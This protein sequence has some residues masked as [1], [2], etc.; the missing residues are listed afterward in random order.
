MDF[1]DSPDEAAYRARVREYLHVHE[2]DLDRGPSDAGGGP[3]DPRTRALR[4]TQAVLYAGGLVGVTW[5]LAYGGQGLSAM[6][7]AIVDQELTRAGI[8]RLINHIG[9][10]MCGPT[11]IAHG[12]EEQRQRY[13][14]RLLSGEDVWCQLFS[15]PSAGS[16]LAAMRTRA[17]R[18]HDTW[19]V[20]GQ[21]V[22]TTGAQIARYG[23]LLARTSPDL[24]KHQGLT[25]FVIDMH[26]SGVQ[27][28]PLRQMSGGT[29]FNEV[30]LDG[31]GIPDRE[32]LGQVGQ[33]W[34]VA[35]TTLLH[36]RSAIGAD[37]KELGAGSDAL[38]ALA[39]T[40]LPGLPTARQAVLRQALGRA[41][42]ESLA[43]RYTG[44]RSL[45]QLSR[46]RLPGPEASAGKLA[47]VRAAKRVADLGVRLL[48]GGQAA[49]F[50]QEDSPALRF[51]TAQAE[52]P[53]M[54]IAG[55]TDEI[56][57]N[58]IGER[59]LGLPREPRPDRAHRS[60]GEHTP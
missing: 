30:F 11:V 56:L 52:L 33:G 5:P 40:H 50:P 39:A 12:S 13:L 23:I 27:V 60:G 15:E 19:T 16:D 44:Y 25:M 58:V 8:P 46:G 18:E 37:G 34:H 1:D 17:V 21:K 22:W 41:V 53:G 10:G 2:A 47:A 6:H 20:H 45:S 57:K 48:E 4:R 51:H 29:R 36:E 14:P 7:Q 28:R 43:S 54:S 24:P 42:A 26:A 49:T 38:I 55:G 32:R 9:I 59:V 3:E 31:A 35:L